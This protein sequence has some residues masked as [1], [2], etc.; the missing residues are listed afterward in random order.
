MMYRN[1]GS[2]TIPYRYGPYD[3]GLCKT[4]RVNARSIR[5]EYAQP[6]RRAAFP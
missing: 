2:A 4:G 6:A 5:L 1:V 3:Y